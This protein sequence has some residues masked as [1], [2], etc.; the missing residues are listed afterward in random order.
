MTQKNLYRGYSSFEYQKNKS[1]SIRDI[2]VVN[3]DLLN[4]IFTPRNSRVMMPTFGTSIS[5]LTFEP[6]DDILV[7]EVYN[8]LLAVFDYDPRVRIINLTVI[9]NF[10]HNALF[11]NARL[12]YVELNI[13][14]DFEL[15]IQF[16][17]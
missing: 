2:D 3:I 7:D 9:P 17:D 12:L 16:E 13:T 15:G 10:E 1:L 8:E 4:H 11:V 14:D 6:L 5:E